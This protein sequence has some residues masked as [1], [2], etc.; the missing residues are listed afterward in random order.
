M[1]EHHWLSSSERVSTDEPGLADR[2]TW[3]CHWRPGFAIGEPPVNETSLTICIDQ[4]I[5]LLGGFDRSL[6]MSYCHR[7]IPRMA[8]PELE[9]GTLFLTIYHDASV[10]I[11]GKWI[12]SEQ[13][14][15]P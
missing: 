3:A 7:Q 12:S 5:Y 6:G 10:S 2:L 13:H 8:R 15:G 14:S 11:L 1:V 4:A 9:K